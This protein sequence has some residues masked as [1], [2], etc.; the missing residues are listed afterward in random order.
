ME[1]NG[2][3]Y[4]YNVGEDMIFVKKDFNIWISILLFLI[5]IQFYNVDHLLTLRLTACVAGCLIIPAVIKDHLE[6]KNHHILKIDRVD[7]FFLLEGTFS[8][9]LEK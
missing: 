7:G 3:Q 8:K 6:E 9:E 1:K 4:K 5:F 2:Y